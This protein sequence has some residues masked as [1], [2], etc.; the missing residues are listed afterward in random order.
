MVGLLRGCGCWGRRKLGPALLALLW[1]ALW[2]NPLWA[3]ATLRGVVVLNEVGGQPL[4]SVPVSAP[5]ANA[6][7]SNSDGTFALV[8][9]Q[10]QP[11][12]EVRVIV[13]RPGWVAVNAIQLTLNLPQSASQKLSE[14]ILCR[15]AEREARQLD[16]FRLKGRQT[17]EREYQGRLAELEGR[18]AATGQ[19][20]DRL[21]RERDQARQQAD[22]M[23]SQLA[24]RVS[25]SEGSLY[26]DALRLY[27]DDRLD[28]ALAKLDDAKLQQRADQ[29]QKEREGTARAFA[30][31]GQMLT[32]KFDFQ[33]A[34]AAY[35]K[36]VK[37]WPESHELW[38]D[39]AYFHQ[40]QNQF[41]EARLGYEEA[42][43][44]YRGSGQKN[45]N[46][47]LPKVALTL[48]NLGV[49]HSDENRH[50]QALQAYEEALKI[51][52]ELAVKNPGLYLSD[53]AMTLNN[54]GNLHRDENRPMQA[55]QAYEEALKIRR[56]L[57]QNNSNIYQPSVALTLI[58]LG[59]LY[60]AEHRYEHALQAYEEALTIYRAQVQRRPDE[61][62]PYVALTLNN[63][64][65]L[66]GD[67]NHQ[68]LALQAFEEALKIRRSLAQKNPN[69]YL[70]NVA[71]TLNNLGLLYSTESRREQA[72]HAYEEALEIGRGLVHRNPEVYLP[73][74]AGTLNNLGNLHRDE[75]RQEQALQ[76]RT[77]TCR[78]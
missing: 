15:E 34:S 31:R 27:L 32:Q 78:V 6:T 63:L 67:E 54:L 17:V 72:L 58:N 18:N 48:N 56:E 52:R 43:R 77:Y 5:G 38:F 3:A 44:I 41:S 7:V 53:V 59:N 1:V 49:L 75:D 11:G 66:H 10:A 22:E 61:Y 25:G 13:A 24:A 19:E 40:K 50:A 71:S 70:P 65:V 64:G 21:L 16:F 9:A 26:Q 14:I 51:R 28:D 60:R 68:E 37:T 33:A 35:E 55:R 62:L 2:A 20:R 57:V 30:L 42:L 39:F 12:D 76:A 36:S 69:V 73:S 4:P 74:I 47:Y 23:A 46:M 45:P 29:L 8:F